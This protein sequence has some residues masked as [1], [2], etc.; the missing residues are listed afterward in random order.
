MDVENRVR[1]DFGNWFGEGEGLTVVH[2]PG[3]VNLIGDHT[4]YND[5]YVL[6]VTIQQAVYVAGRLRSDTCIRVY[7][8]NFD[9]EY[10]CSLGAPVTRGASWDRFVQGVTEAVHQ[11]STLPVG[12]DAVLFGD[13]PIGS[14]LS[15]SAATEVAL[16]RFIEALYQHPIA[17]V[18]GA[19]LC[20]RV[21][22]EVIGLQCGIMDQFASRLGRDQHALFLDCRSLDFEE[23][24]MRLGQAQV[25]IVD[26]KTQ[27]S[28][29]ASK[30]NE[31]RAECEAGVEYFSR[32]Q[33]DI[34]ALRDVD[35]ELFEAHTSG[36]DE[37]IRSRCRHVIYENERV[38]EAANALR[39]GEVD[40][41]G[42]LMTA[43]HESLR[44]LYAVS[45]AEIDFLV[46]EALR[47]D[48]VYGAR[49]TGA[50]FGG[51][52]VSLV[53][54]EAVPSVKTRLQKAYSTAFGIE[55][56]FY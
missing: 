33:D 16:L 8:V 45:C 48:G 31:R 14:G 50:G 20:Q 40:R 35:T 55:P 44:D 17:P 25:L 9:E 46:E 26:S 7:S 34:K 6:P 53:H 32:I 21:E 43:S 23:I 47:I 22:H 51:C 54:T 3:R 19:F 52:M 24:P 41:L 2:A 10:S 13:V 29:A 42:A 27:R 15:S 30:Y 56:A 12:F 4:D 37:R 39:S 1:E 49:I 11:Q 28:L 36:L 38:L 18:E 5:G